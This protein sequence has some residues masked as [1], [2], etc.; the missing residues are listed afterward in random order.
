[1]R[2]VHESQGDTDAGIN[3]RLRS[4]SAAGKLTVAGL[5]AAAGGIAIQIASGADYSTVPPGL[6][7]LLVAAGL[8]A[9]ATRWWWTLWRAWWCRPSS[10]SAARSRP[11]P[12][13]TWAIRGVGV[14]IGTVIQ[15]LALV[16]ALVAS[17]AATRQ[18]YQA[19][20]G[21]E[22]LGRCPAVGSWPSAAV[23]RPRATGR[24]GHGGSK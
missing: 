3:D 18:G 17:V 9:L 24:S 15:P 2:V 6:V 20:P 21:H 10:C 8:V 5:V 11:I 13:T 14:F 16:I 22:E 4:L 19:G 1:M 7:I 23:G 12:E